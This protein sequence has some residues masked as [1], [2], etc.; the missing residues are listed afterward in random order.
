MK[1]DASSDLGHDITEKEETINDIY[2]LIVG[3]II[4][5]S[6]G[7]WFHTYFRNI[8]PI[9]VYYTSVAF[10]VIF[11]LIIYSYYIFYEIYQIRE[12]VS[13]EKILQETKYE[14]DREEKISG[15]IPVILFGVGIVYTNIQKQSKIKINLLQLSSPYLLFSLMF[16]TVIPNIISYLIFDNTNLKRLLTA[17]YFSFISVSIAF[18]LMITSLLV[19]FF[20]HYKVI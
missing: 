14:I 17:S 13:K 5:I 18:G 7:L 6:F 2:M 9:K 3:Y 19:P 16:G 20:T 1:K 12:H 15:I 4:I 11:P 10:V 8:M